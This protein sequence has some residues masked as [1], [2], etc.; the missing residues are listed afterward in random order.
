MKVGTFSYRDKCQRHICAGI[1]YRCSLLKLKR[2][3]EQT[4]PPPTGAALPPL[5]V[6]LERFQVRVHLEKG[7]KVRDGD[8]A[9]LVCHGSFRRSQSSTERE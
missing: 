9:L 3:S 4:P 1:L 6:L 2:S 7:A 5:E 8:A